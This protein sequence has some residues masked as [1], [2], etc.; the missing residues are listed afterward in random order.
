MKVNWLILFCL[1]SANLF[2]QGEEVGPLS[3]NPALMAKNTRYLIKANSGTFDST[4]IYIPDTISLPVFDEFS[5]DKFQVYNAD[6]GDPGVTSDKKYRLLDG[7]LVPLGD[8]EYYTVQQTFRRVFDIGNSTIDDQPFSAISIKVGDLSEYPV[9]YVTTNVYPPFYIYDT[10]DY[11]NDPDTIWLTNPD[12]FQDS[13]TQFFASL[14]DPDKIWLDKE[15]FHNFTLALD[16]WT[17]GVV[18]FDGL[19]EFGYPYA[20]GTT[21]SGIADHLTSKPIDMSAVSAADSVY[22]SFLYQTEG[23]GDV[24]EG[25]DGDSLFLEFYAI[26]QDEWRQVWSTGGESVTEFK[27]GHLLLDNTDYFKK[28]FQFRF[29]NYGGLSGSL[30]HFH[31]DYIRLRSLSGYQD[32]LFKDFALVYPLNSLLKDYTSVPW[33]HYKA[34]FANKMS[35]NVQVVVRN[36]SNIPENNQNGTC[37]VSYVA[38]PEGSFTLVGQDLSGGNFNYDPRTTYYS[39]HD[40]SSGYHF[41]ETKPG[42]S[43]TFDFLTTVSAPFAHFTG[44]DSTLSQQVFNNYYAYDDG[45]AEA[46]YGPTGIQSRLAIQYTPYEADSL[47]GVMIHFVPSVNDVS[48]K[49]FLLTVWD[50]DNGKPGDTLYQ[51]KSF[52]PR[53]PEYQYDRNIFTTYYFRDTMKVPVN[54]TFYVGWRQFEADRLNVGL[55]RNILNNNHTFYSVDNEATWETSSIPGSVMIRPI[56][57][58]GLDV[59]LGL[60]EKSKVEDKVLIYPNPTEQSITVDA[61][62]FD[63]KEM[64]LYSLQGNL[65]SIAESNIM[66]IIDLPSGVYFLKIEGLN[67]TY[68]VIRR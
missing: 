36:N 6:Y 50:D 47:I 55:D 37:E 34:N 28:G 38:L 64:R 16:P 33:D 20:F 49:L 67:G 62:M 8:D 41:D 4:F 23:L 65:V 17:L 11:P 19:D 22:F 26:D 35:D 9:N 7:S 53:T 25:N 44:N 45:S 52:F 51:D 13:A 32:T 66:N 48:D 27:V 15:A 3:G 29:K 1:I 5:S 10:L 54:G 61:G 63:I 12:I 40:F 21:T 60:N 14:N 56:F 24:P 57:S 58:T 68:K 31:V 43:Q 59:T 39:Y 42:L 46:A 30:D 2:A 18:S